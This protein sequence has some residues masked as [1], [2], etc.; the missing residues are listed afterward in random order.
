MN[1][2]GTPQNDHDEHVEKRDL[3][4]LSP[5][6]RAKRFLKNGMRKRNTSRY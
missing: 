3:K 2:P 5:F 4:S 6:N 1:I